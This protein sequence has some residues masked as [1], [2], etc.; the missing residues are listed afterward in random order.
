MTKVKTRCLDVFNKVQFEEGSYMLRDE[1]CC[2]CFPSSGDWAVEGGFL[3]LSTLP[4][5]FQLQ[6]LSGAA[7][8]GLEQLTV[9]H[10]SS[11]GTPQLDGPFE[12][13]AQ[14]PSAQQTLSHRPPRESWLNG[15]HD[16]DRELWNR[17]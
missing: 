13:S 3:G 6:G 11:R 14:L 10:S 1:I 7:L 4:V 15:H 2:F 17:T 8:Q 16:G 9:T 12:S 5:L